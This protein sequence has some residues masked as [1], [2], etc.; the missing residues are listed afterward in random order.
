MQPANSVEEHL[1]AIVFS[2]LLALISSGIAWK[3]GFFSLPKYNKADSPAIYFSELIAV[4]AL[5]LSVSLFF[6]PL[7]LFI[8]NFFETGSWTSI[9]HNSLDV[10]MQGWLNVVMILAY[11]CG[12]GLFCKGCS[13][14]LQ[15]AVWGVNAYAGKKRRL[16][17]F[18]FGCCSWLIAFPLV[19]VIDQ[20]TSLIVLKLFEMPPIDQVAVKHLK[21][22]LGNPLLFFSLSLLIISIVPLVEEIL[23]RGFLQTWLKQRLGRKKAIVL[24]SLIFACFHFS[25]EQGIY[26]MQILFSLFLLSCFLGFV[27][28]RQQSLWTSIGLHATFNGIS[29]LAILFS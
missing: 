2:M 10:Q 26:N 8:W 24:A 13:T 17:D 12:I 1:V 11:A 27:Y 4:F 5:F 15:Y 20:F 3:R 25:P 19:L 21:T 18:M 16:E 14:R 28:E 23:F 29:T 22:T 6:P 7:L 9:P